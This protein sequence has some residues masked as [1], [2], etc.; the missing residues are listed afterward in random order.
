MLA[1]EL[2]IGH[3]KVDSQPLVLFEAAFVLRITALD[4]FQKPESVQHIHPLGS[5]LLR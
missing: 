1:Q 3:I 5:V 4:Q 2:Y